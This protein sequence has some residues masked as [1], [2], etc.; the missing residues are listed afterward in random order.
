MS[1]YQDDP[2]SYVPSVPLSEADKAG[3]GKQSA[4][5][6]S[7]SNNATGKPGE[8]L[9]DA[10]ME[11]KGEGEDF[12]DKTLTGNPFA[13]EFTP[14]GFKRTATSVMPSKVALFKQEAAKFGGDDFANMFDNT[15]TDNPCEKNGQSPKGYGPDCEF[16][17]LGVAAER[18]CLFDGKLKCLQTYY[19]AIAKCAPRDRRNCIAGS[20]NGSYFLTGAVSET[21]AKKTWQLGGVPR[22]SID[23]ECA[24]GFGRAGT[25]YIYLPGSSL[26]CNGVSGEPCYKEF[27]KVFRKCIKDINKRCACQ[28]CV[29]PP[30]PPE[31]KK[32][33][34]QFS[35]DEE[36][37]GVP[38]P[39]N[40][41]EPGPP[42]TRVKH[43]VSSH[44]IPIPL[45]FGRT[46]VGGNIIWMGDTRVQ[47]V[48]TTDTNLSSD[49]EPS[50]TET[51]VQTANMVFGLADS[52]LAHVLD[53]ASVSG[54]SAIWVGD[55]KVYQS[56]LAPD[57]DPYDTNVTSATLDKF[58]END[59][60]LV[61]TVKFYS[62]RRGQNPPTFVT[63]SQYPN[64]AEIGYRGLAIAVIDNMDVTSLGDAFPSVTFEVY[65]ATDSPYEAGVVQV[66]ENLSTETLDADFLSFDISTRTTYASSA[67]AGKTRAFD[68]DTLKEIKQGV[69]NIDA[70][71]SGKFVTRMG[72]VLVQDRGVSGIG[73][74]TEVH[75]SNMFYDATNSYTW[76]RRSGND[77][78]V[79]HGETTF[80]GNAEGIIAAGSTLNTYLAANNRPGRGAAIHSLSVSGRD[81]Y[82]EEVVFFPS[83][84]DDV[85][86]LYTA[87]H[88]RYTRPNEVY[89]G[90]AEGDSSSCL[91]DCGVSFEANCTSNCSYGTSGGC[92][93]SDGFMVNVLFGT[94][95][96]LEAD[97]Q[98]ELDYID[99]SGN[100][101]V[102]G[103]GAAI[104]T[105]IC[106]EPESDPEV[107]PE[108]FTDCMTY[109]DEYCTVAC[110]DSKVID[111]IS[112]AVLTF[113]GSDPDRPGELKTY[114]GEA[115]V[116]FYRPT[117]A[118]DTSPYGNMTQLQVATRFVVTNR[119]G[120]GADYGP[121]SGY[122]QVIDTIPYT[123]WNNNSNTY[124]A[125]I[126]KCPDNTLALFIKAQNGED[127]IVRYS[128]STRTVLY[129]RRL[130]ASLP[131][132]F[133][134]GLR[135]LPMNLEQS[136]YAYIS[137]SGA[138]VVVDMVTGGSEILHNVYDGPAV[139][140]AQYFDPENGSIVYIGGN[141]IYKVFIGYEL[142]AEVQLSTIV[143]AIFIK[144]GMS[145][146]DVFID[147]DN[148]QSIIG[149]TID[150]LARAKDFFQQLT[151]VFNYVISSDATI[152]VA[153][154]VSSTVTLTQNEVANKSG[155][156]QQREEKNLI[157]YTLQT[158]DL[159]NPAT[160][161]VVR[162]TAEFDVL[163]ARDG[164][165]QL[166]DT[167]FV[168]DLQQQTELVLAHVAEKVDWTTQIVFSN[169]LRKP[170]LTPGDIINVDSPNPYDDNVETTT[171]RIKETNYGNYQSQIV[172]V[173]ITNDGVLEAE[174]VVTPAN[175][176]K[177]FRGQP[178][179][180][181]STAIDDGTADFTRDAT[182]LLYTGVMS[183]D[184]VFRRQAPILVG[185]AGSTSNTVYDQTSGFTATARTSTERAHTG[186][187]TIALP[188]LN[189]RL[190]E[191]N[192]ERT[193]TL[194]FDTKDSADFVMSQQVLKTDP[195]WPEF[196][197]KLIN[198]NTTNLLI[199]DYG[200]QI[201]F[202]QAT[203]LS[204]R[205]IVVTGI[206]RGRQGTEAL[207]SAGLEAAAKF[208][209]YT[210][211]GV[212]TNAITANAVQKRPQVQLIWPQTQHFERHLVPDIYP[213][214]SIGADLWA[215]QYAE[216]KDV[217]ADLYIRWQPRSI[218]TR[219][220]HNE[221]DE[222]LGT[223]KYRLYIMAY[224][225]L[226]GDAY[227]DWAQVVDLESRGNLVRYV[228]PIIETN[229]ILLP[230]SLF[231]NTLNMRPQTPGTNPV[232]ELH[233]MVCPVHPETGKSGLPH[234]ARF[235][236]GVYTDWH[237]IPN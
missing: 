127:Y 231:S 156:K 201:Q 65:T 181:P 200:E 85:A 186:R 219:R 160:P 157:A 44:G 80:V 113:E 206:Y 70:P 209:Y 59:E 75:L 74:R 37:A 15:S 97:Q 192:Y 9:R 215:P 235:K 189:Y 16:Q 117:F 208:V 96:D 5:T 124:L 68:F 194:E 19:S 158:L 7:A 226:D 38:Y 76:W 1:T 91:F 77:S 20:I 46:L 87:K 63:N 53:T 51:T 138:V 129:A 184:D 36:K 111:G 153:P 60:R 227:A 169:D 109:L 232:N 179:M 213:A 108:C 133:S 195:N 224:I 99:A 55:K 33:P 71:G 79:G 197:T 39:T 57:F 143:K 199:F 130:A 104:C 125:Q 123:H 196:K 147:T 136:G 229:E 177:R 64:A 92:F 82:P 93:A 84:F 191:P 230:A 211:R 134:S 203:R 98:Y 2:F 178:F 170:Q 48:F 94:V 149:Y 17:D 107:D 21:L 88:T 31:E 89:L 86:L 188:V 210:P 116:L 132:Y 120:W 56:A 135:A 218:Y 62:G 25:G 145:E 198:T 72:D 212:R 105:Y 221:F 214:S 164:Y 146:K 141:N 50:E 225:P 10:G 165:E 144:A 14:P 122:P 106:T 67:A 45:V 23:T 22:P 78:G 140:G 174:E 236:A 29:Q 101:F 8:G 173:K 162:R 118:M 217:G 28:S 90:S 228:S 176:R 172:A 119:F 150:S 216:R 121:A 202:E 11:G 58:N 30:D 148:D 167:K 49:D 193:L 54:I 233:I 159:N 187:T 128:P 4:E 207:Q 115:F 155:I 13:F 100:V 3:P 131:A 81:L 27:K 114:Y 69:T 42:V 220:E 35:A 163:D 18:Q 110:G 237:T 83:R 137:A 204:D 24:I 180:F 112:D 222:F 154:I 161:I 166:D 168:M 66:S 151:S 190:F 102:V 234:T 43:T 41:E 126:L 183:P 175:A 95:L 223:P 26:C 12:D 40:P 47:T 142:M 171:Y 34:G 152:R 139:T 185:R 52:S 32:E 182:A 205:K 6:N 61:P 103:Q 73:R